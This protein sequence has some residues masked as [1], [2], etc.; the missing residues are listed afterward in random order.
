MFWK[1]FFTTFKIIYTLIKKYYIQIHEI[2]INGRM[3][4]NED[5]YARLLEEFRPEIPPMTVDK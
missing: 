1:C 2:D 3:V 5:K 4:I